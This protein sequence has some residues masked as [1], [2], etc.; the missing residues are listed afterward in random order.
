MMLLATVF[1]ACSD[2]D[3]K[4]E[5]DDDKDKETPWEIKIT[6][7]V[8]W[9]TEFKFELS[10]GYHDLS[11]YTIDWGDGSEAESF[12]NTRY[13]S[14]YYD[15]GTYSITVKGR[16]SVHFGHDQ[17]YQI[18]F[19]DITSLNVS[20][21]TTLVSL[22]CCG[23]QLTSLDVTKCTALEA[24]SCENNQLTSLDI[25]KCPNL[26][27]LYCGSNNFDDN[28]MN[29]I[30]NGLPDRTGKEAGVF[31]INGNDAKGNTTIALNKNWK[32]KY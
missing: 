14:H 11:A 10:D 2:D 8:E 7:N 4:D 18:S 12:E 15:Q 17:R 13:P 26:N 25:T 27:Q 23:H 22:I 24:L 6:V 28:A 21:C 1:V 20:D 32:V 16:G 29:A 3:D 30:Y 31:Y 5:K 19:L 9:K